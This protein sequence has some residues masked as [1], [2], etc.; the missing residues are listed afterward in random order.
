MDRLYHEIVELSAAGAPFTLA[1]VVHASGSTPQKAGARALFLADGQVLGTLGG[2][3][4]E[5]ESRRRGLELIREGEPLLYDLHLDDDF[6]WDD[7]LICGG[8]AQIFLQ[9]MRRVE[10]APFAEALA[11]LESGGRGVLA[12]LVGGTPEAA[13][14]TLLVRDDGAAS[15]SVPE[16]VRPALVAAALQILAEERE[17]PR[18]LALPD[19]AGTA[20]LEPILPRPT[21]LIAGAGH[22]GAALAQFAA[23]I[24][25]SVAVVDDRPSFA[26]PER[27]PDADQVIVDDIVAGVRRFPKTPQT[28][29]VIVTRGHR[30]DAVVLR[31][32]IDAPVAYIGMIGSRRKVLTIFNE[33]MAEGLATPERLARVHAPIGLDIGA[34]SVE[35][36]A[37]SIAAELIAVRRKGSSRLPVAGSQR[38]EPGTFEPEELGERSD[39]GHGDRAGSG[40]IA[41]D[42]TAEGA[43]ALR[44]SERARHGRSLAQSLPDPRPD[45]R[46]RPPRDCAG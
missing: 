14:A 45:R 5:A 24:G 33:F 37:V 30:N 36:I 15:G 46:G 29:V 34:L 13:G 43:L 17:E 12:T 23:R 35:E 8:T 21:L 3:C 19:G 4:M 2:G 39:D 41:A 9:P 28:Y 32:V 11:L 1:T 16:A 40:G 27:L 26:N 25:F 20:Y 22:V 42:G 44:Q 6:G 10:P 18:R 31:E 7:G 38:R